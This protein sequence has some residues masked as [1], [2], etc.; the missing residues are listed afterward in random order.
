METPQKTLKITALT[1][2]ETAR[3]LASASGKSITE[4]DVR[5][6]AEQGN[7]IAADGT[8]NLLEYTAF[9]VRELAHGTD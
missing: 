7:L 9:L 1:V 5:T 8:I 6:V 4:E 2:A 3:V